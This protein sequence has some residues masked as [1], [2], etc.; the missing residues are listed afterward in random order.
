M[1]EL[2]ERVTNVVANT[3][4]NIVNPAVVALMAAAG[5]AT[6]NPDLAIAAVPGGALAGALADEGVALVRRAW[7]DRSDRVG[8]FASTAAKEAGVPIEELIGQ[9]TEDPRL[10]ELMA[11]TVESAAGAFDTTKVEILARAFVRGAKDGAAIDEMLLLVEIL[12]G[13]EVPHIRLLAAVWR[14]GPGATGNQS[15]PVG[16][17]TLLDNN[18]ANSDPALAPVVIPLRRKLAEQDLVEEVQ[19]GTRLTDYG[20]YVAGALNDLGVRQLTAGAW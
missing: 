3:T 2:V 11:R 1:G 13:L 16:D 10:R 19:G 15:R 12:R 18:I 7:Q 5:V 6:G 17:G 14:Q 20:V 8:R 9:T 4:G